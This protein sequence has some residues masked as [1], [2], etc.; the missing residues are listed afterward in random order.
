MRPVPKKE[1]PAHI[2]KNP[3]GRAPVFQ[4]EQFKDT[5]NQYNSIPVFQA[6]N[7]QLFAPLIDN[8]QYEKSRQTPEDVP[9][10]IFLFSIFFSVIKE[11]VDCSTDLFVC[12]RKVHISM[13]DAL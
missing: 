1:H 7:S 2:F 12:H 13:A 3:K 8:D 9:A 10:V 5:R 11:I 6:M 4:I